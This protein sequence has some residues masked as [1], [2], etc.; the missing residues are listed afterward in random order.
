MGRKWACTGQ[1]VDL[2]A[3]AGADGSGGASDEQRLIGECRREGIGVQVNEKGVGVDPAGDTDGA[4]GR[5]GGMAAVA[6]LAQPVGDSAR[7]GGRLGGGPGGH[8]RIHVVGRGVEWRRR[9]RLH[10]RFLVGKLRDNQVT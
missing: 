1:G 3:A 10:H 6:D 5:G 8:G 4:A 2:G 9:S 7:P